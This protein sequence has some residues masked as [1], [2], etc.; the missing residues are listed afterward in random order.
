[1]D[2][3]IAGLVPSDPAE[4]PQY[5]EELAQKLE[6]YINGQPAIRWDSHPTVTMNLVIGRWTTGSNF[7]VVIPLSFI[8]RIT[9]ILS[10]SALLDLQISGSAGNDTIDSL[11]VATPYGGPTVTLLGTATTGGQ[12]SGSACTLQLLSGAD[13][14]L[15]LDASY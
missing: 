11:S 5:L 2:D 3:F 14:F 6:T 10:Y 8:P 7:Q 4:L 9:P 13:K 1:M 15:E 12:T